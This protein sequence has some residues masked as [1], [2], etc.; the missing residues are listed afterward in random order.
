L[1]HSCDDAWG[2]DILAAACT[3]LGATVEPGLLE[4]VW[5]A[6][7]YIDGHYDD[8]AGIE[9]S[10]GHIALPAGPGL[11]IVPDEARFGAPVLVV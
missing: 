1:P 5:I 10:G 9:I 6:A 7:P 11:G 4:G 2:G 3:H 8:A